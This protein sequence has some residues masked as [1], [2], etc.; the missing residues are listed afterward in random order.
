MLKV[1]EAAD[2][3]ELPPNPFNFPEAN[4]LCYAALRPM[5]GMADPLGEDGENYAG[6]ALS[7]LM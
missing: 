2:W 5:A 7:A 3:P 6:P 1:H 4:L